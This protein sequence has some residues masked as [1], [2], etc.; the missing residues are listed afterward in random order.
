MSVRVGEGGGDFREG[1]GNEVCRKGVWGEVSV[2]R[3]GGISGIEGSGGLGS[4]DEWRRE[5]K[6]RVKGGNGNRKIWSIKIVE[7]NK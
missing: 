2:W 7:L 6:L 1:V 3:G 4:G 5:R